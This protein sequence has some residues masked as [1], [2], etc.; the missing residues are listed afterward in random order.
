M[1]FSRILCCVCVWFSHI[2]TAITH[3]LLL[4]LFTQNEKKDKLESNAK[5]KEYLPKMN[6][7]N[8]WKLH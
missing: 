3:T 4:R 8:E 1:K 2:G 7:H 6:L 5:E